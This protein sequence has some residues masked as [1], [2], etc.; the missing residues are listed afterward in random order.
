MY[1]AGLKLNQVIKR[2]QNQPMYASFLIY[3]SNGVIVLTSRK[4]SISYIEG[5]FRKVQE[6]RTKPLRVFTGFTM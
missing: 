6:F 5:Y 4:N 3:I 1:L 2:C